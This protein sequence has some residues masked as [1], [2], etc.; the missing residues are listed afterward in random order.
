MK[1]VFELAK[2][3]NKRVG[4][5]IQMSAPDYWNEPAL[6]D[7]VLDKVPTVDLI[8]DEKERKSAARFIENPYS[9]Y[10]PR[11]DDPFFQQAFAE[12][13]AFKQRNSM[14]T[15]R[16]IR[17]YLPLWVLGRGAHVALH[18]HSFPRLPDRRAHLG[19][20]VAKCNWSTSPGLH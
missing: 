4:L 11:F 15:L 20:N 14:E 3:N 13:W 12:L 7:F 10:Q 19:K 16:R 18:Q 1:L 8:P 5:R 17:R 6:P 9:R 2:K